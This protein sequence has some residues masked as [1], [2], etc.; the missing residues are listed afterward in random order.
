MSFGTFHALS[1]ALVGLLAQ[2]YATSPCCPETDQSVLCNAFRSLSGHEQSGVMEVFGTECPSTMPFTD[3][4][5][6]AIEKRKPNFI[7]FGRSVP[8]Q[9]AR[10]GSDPNFL[11]FGKR[12][13][14]LVEAD[15]E[16]GAPGKRASANGPTA[17]FLRFGRSAVDTSFMRNQKSSDP[18][19]LRFGKRDVPQSMFN[20]ESA[21]PNFLRFGRAGVNNNFLRFGRA[22]DDDQFDREYRK[23]NFLRFG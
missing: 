1:I 10:K 22:A 15:T 2:V 16:D 14:A 19:F 11:R 21:E 13:L 17:N 3:N 7:R 12:S 6:N 8:S 5:V 18:N 23:P 9:F 20:E 4:T